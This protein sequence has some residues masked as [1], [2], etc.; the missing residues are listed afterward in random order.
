MAGVIADCYGGP[1]SNH[2]NGYLLALSF[3]TAFGNAGHDLA[4]CK[5]CIFSLFF[6]PFY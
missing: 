2:F 3:T 5:T 4:T 6:Q 1:H